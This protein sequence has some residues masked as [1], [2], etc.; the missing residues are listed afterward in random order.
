VKP[1]VRNFAATAALLAPPA[2]S[3]TIRARKAA[4]RAL[5][6]CRAMR[7]NATRCKLFTNSSCFFG[8]PRRGSI[9]Q[10][11]THPIYMQPIYDS[12]D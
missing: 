6:D 10:H 7:S 4:D 5:R 11:K 1:V 3:R 9:P 12:V 8:R 2:H